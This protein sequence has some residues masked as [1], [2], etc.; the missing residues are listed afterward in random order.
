MGFWNNVKDGAGL[1]LGGSFGARIGWELGGWVVTWLKR[2]VV[3]LVIG[4]AGL[5]HKLD[6]GFF[7]SAETSKPVVVQKQ[8]A[9]QPALAAPRA[10]VNEAR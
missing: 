7:S 1:G 2:L 8:G 5:Y 4:L 3:L 9:H 10:K 6:S